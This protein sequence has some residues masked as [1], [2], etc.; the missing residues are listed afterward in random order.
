M[1]LAGTQHRGARVG[2]EDVNQAAGS[3]DVTKQEELQFDLGEEEG[4]RSELVQAY[5]NI[6][7]F[8][9]QIAKVNILLVD[10]D[11]AKEQLEL[12]EELVDL[13]LLHKIQSNVSISKRQGKKFAAYMLDLSQYTGERKI[14]SFDM[15][16]FWDRDANLRQVKFIYDP[17]HDHRKKVSPSKLFEKSFPIIGSTN[18]QKKKTIET[19]LFGEIIDED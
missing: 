1:L 18:E 16:N 8:C 14:R 4:G 13:R 5:E 12:I 15:V 3:Y 17:S 9:T 11:T 19:P 7:I 6:R 2:A 10:K